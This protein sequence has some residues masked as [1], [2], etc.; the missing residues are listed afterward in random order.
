MVKKTPPP[1]TIAFVHVYHTGAIDTFDLRLIAENQ[2]RRD[3]QTI[4]LLVLPNNIDAQVLINGPQLEGCAPHTVA[5]NNS[6]TGA[7]TLTWNFGDNTPVISTPNS[8]NTVGHTF[9]SG[10]VFTITHPAA[11]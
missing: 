10:G 4:T 9:A 8:Q 3:T 1:V 2:C 7:S 11:E 5:F 6:S